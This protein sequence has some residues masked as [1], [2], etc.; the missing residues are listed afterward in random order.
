MVEEEVERLLGR[1][2]QQLKM[3]GLS[4]EQYL[5]FTQS[6]M[7]DLEKQMKEA[8]KSYDFEKAAELRDIILEMRSEFR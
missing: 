4:I 7:E 8:A 6:T 5:E 2:E 1:Y 3:Q